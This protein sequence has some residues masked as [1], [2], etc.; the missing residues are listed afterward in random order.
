MKS[1]N[2]FFLFLALLML[3]SLSFAHDLS[4]S[5]FSATPSV[6]SPGQTFKLTLTLKNNGTTDAEDIRVVVF[7]DFPF[8][9][10]QKEK[11][12]SVQSNKQSTLTFYLSVDS[13]AKDGTYTLGIG[14]GKRTLKREDI[15][16]TIRSEY[17]HIEIISSNLKEIAPG[18]KKT[19]ILKLKNT[20]NST[21][22]NIIVK[23]DNDYSVSAS[24]T[25]I[26]RAITTLGASTNPIPKLEPNQEKEVSFTISADPDSDLKAYLLPFTIDY[27]S[28]SNTHYSNTSYTGLFIN[29]KENIDATIEYDSSSMTISVFN[30]GFAKAKFL[31]AEIDSDLDID[32]TKVFVGSLDADDFDSFKLHFTP[33]FGEK[34][35][36]VKFSYLDKDAKKVSVEKTFK[37]NLKPKQQGFYLP[38]QEVFALIGLVYSILYIYNRFIK[39]K[40]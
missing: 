11:I 6:L 33:S 15:S 10:S 19:L 39:K 32:Q 26:K 21:A 35:I 13:L 17:P 22:K 7:D 9:A 24:G 20:G 31:V 25:I 4:L 1:K 16:L 30:T 3:S 28:L 36:K 37:I 34:T 8:K 23:Y 5:S 12:T 29:G 18:E 40:K 14:Y 27:Y 2:L 38:I